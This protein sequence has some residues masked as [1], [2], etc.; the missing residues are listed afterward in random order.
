[1]SE[2]IQQSTSKDVEGSENEKPPSRTSAGGMAALKLMKRLSA[3]KTQNVS[4]EKESSGSKR[5]LEGAM[6]ALTEPKRSLDGAVKALKRM[7]LA[8]GSDGSSQ[9]T[10][11]NEQANKKVAMGFKKLGRAQLGLQSLL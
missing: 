8:Q 9:D 3:D 4:A 1:M 2:K 11:I 6:R 7:S 10:V 5:A